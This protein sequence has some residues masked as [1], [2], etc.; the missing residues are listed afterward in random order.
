MYTYVLFNGSAT[1][2]T[3]FREQLA[4]NR[5][6]ILLATIAK[7]DNV[8]SSS[9]SDARESTNLFLIP[10]TRLNAKT[11]EIAY[12]RQLSDMYRV[13][14]QAA[15]AKDKELGKR[16]RDGK[17]PFLLAT[18]Q[19]INKTV[20]SKPGQ[21]TFAVD[22]RQPILLVDLTWANE[23]SVTEIVRTFKTHV[24]DTPLAGIDTLDPL[25]LK[26]VSLLLDVNDAIPLVRNAV[27]GTC[28]SI[29]IEKTCAQ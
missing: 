11:A 9:D 16:L 6:K 7:Q 18:L 15:F 14:F 27:A 20:K 12:D 21:K 28:K 4:Y 29:G 24:S 10:G 26:L 23:K 13:Y 25:R 22:A 17:G 1:N 8:M 19:P 3:T 2:P 5:L